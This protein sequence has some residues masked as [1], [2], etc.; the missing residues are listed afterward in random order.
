MYI[1]IIKSNLYV[2]KFVEYLIDLGT[3]C[4]N[5]G[6]IFI[7]TDTPKESQ[8]SKKA[9]LDVFKENI[10]NGNNTLILFGVFFIFLFIIFDSLVL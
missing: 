10:I 2:I 5:G 8:S 4:E 9:I 7:V 1:V 6:E 3:E